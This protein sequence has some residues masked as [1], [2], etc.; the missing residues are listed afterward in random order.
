VLSTN[1]QQS[2]FLIFL[3]IL[4]ISSISQIFK[5]GLVGVS[6]QTNFVSGL[7]AYSTFFKSV[8]SMKSIYI[9]KFFIAKFLIYLYVPPYTSSQQI[10]WSPDFKQW[11][12][13][14]IAPHPLEKAIPYFPYSHSAKQFSKASLVGFPHRV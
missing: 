6:I 4:T 8:K 12:T 5:V 2:S 3:V 9:P 13:A 14:D 11:M 7:K 1:T 10:T